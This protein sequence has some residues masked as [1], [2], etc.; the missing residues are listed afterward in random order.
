MSFKPEVAP[1][2]YGVVFVLSNRE[3]KA[4]IRQIATILDQSD[5]DSTSYVVDTSS[6][7]IGRK[8]AKIDE[9]G[10]YKIYSGRS[11]RRWR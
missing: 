1:V 4:W 2:L 10:V 8:Y 11:N 6:S 3:Q 7:S 5:V 9:I